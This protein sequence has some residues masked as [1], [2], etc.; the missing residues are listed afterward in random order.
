MAV[1]LHEVLS[2]TLR[3][4]KLSDKLLTTVCAPQIYDKDDQSLRNN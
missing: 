2:S 1:A 3:L 4:K